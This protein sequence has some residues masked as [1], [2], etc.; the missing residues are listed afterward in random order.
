LAEEIMNML[1]KAEDFVM[2][3]LQALDSLGGNA[4]ISEVEDE[5]Y[6]RFAGRLDPSIDWHKI[7]PNHGNELWRDYCGTRVAFQCLRPEGYVV[8]ERL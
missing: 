8:T 2:P 7:T 3:A 5:F 1:T 6:K 4:W